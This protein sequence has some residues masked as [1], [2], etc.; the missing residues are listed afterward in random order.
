MDPELTHR[1]RSTWED[2]RGEVRTDSGG[3]HDA[4]WEVAIIGSVNATCAGP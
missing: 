2:D 1:S 4:A 3:D